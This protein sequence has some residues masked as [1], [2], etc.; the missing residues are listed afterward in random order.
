[1]STQRS[2]PLCTHKTDLD[3]RASV[4][5]KRTLKRIG[6]RRYEAVLYLL[7]SKGVDFAVTCF[8]SIKIVI[9]SL[10]PLFETIKFKERQKE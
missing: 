8:L 4:W 2:A 7:V 6:I 3:Y 10:G 5:T 9:I 1:M